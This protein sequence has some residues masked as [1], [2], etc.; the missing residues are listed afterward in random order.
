MNKYV[1]ESFCKLGTEWVFE[2]NYLFDS[3]KDALNF[4]G[5]EVK[6]W[7]AAIR[8]VRASERLRGN[9]WIVY[10]GEKEYYKY[11]MKRLFKKA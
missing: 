6:E 5:V 9:N 8:S 7:L 4:M 3:H 10:R 11:H 2:F 1:V